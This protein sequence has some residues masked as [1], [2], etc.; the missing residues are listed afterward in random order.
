[1]SDYRKATSVSIDDFEGQAGPMTLRE[2]LCFAA[3]ALFGVAADVGILVG[4]FVYGNPVCVMLA[5][6]LIAVWAAFAVW[7][8]NAV[9]HGFRD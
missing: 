7:L 1:M 3:V 2:K 4:A 9:A 8:V 5:T 6:V